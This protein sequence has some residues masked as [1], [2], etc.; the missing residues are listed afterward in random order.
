MRKNICLII[1]SICFVTCLCGCQRRSSSIQNVSPMVTSLETKAEDSIPISTVSGPSPEPTKEP[2]SEPEPIPTSE[3]T[4]PATPEPI[5][6]RGA[7]TSE[8]ISVSKHPG[9]E[10]VWED[11]SA[12]FI[13]YADGASALEWYFT[14]ADGTEEY[15]WDSDTIHELFPALQC[16]GG[17][18]NLFELYGIPLELNGWSVFCLFSDNAGG[19]LA[20]QEAII[21]I[22]PQ[23]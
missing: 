9:G 17:D 6:Y 19:L 23:S 12:V 20:S 2:L 10:T 5:R 8:L 15:V 13:S 14:N 11:G 1:T 22:L 3:P 21:E 7:G 18:T 4:I 16:C